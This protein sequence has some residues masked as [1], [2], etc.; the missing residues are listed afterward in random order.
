MARDTLLEFPCRFPIK[1]FGAQDGDFEQTVFELV[2]S[3]VP[4]LSSDDISR[5]ASRAG[6][7]LA[8]T[9]EIRAQS[10]AQLDA[11]Y[12]DLSASDSVLMAL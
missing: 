3:H 7:Y 6:N 5:N 2:K 9:V 10:Q 8:V 11:I 12:A 1:A 4:E